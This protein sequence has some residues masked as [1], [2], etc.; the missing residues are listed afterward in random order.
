MEQNN[1]P[2]KKFRAGS[3]SCSVFENHGN[4][5]GRETVFPTVSLQRAYKDK[6]GIWK[7]SASL[8]AEEIPKAQLVL[9][10]AYEFLSLKEVE[11]AA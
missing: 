9:G 5:N 1:K 2:V 10:K 3:V 6:S 11:A 8:R 7:N 4:V